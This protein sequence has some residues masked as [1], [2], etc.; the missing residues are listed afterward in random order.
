MGVITFN[1]LD[2]ALDDD[3]RAA[4]EEADIIIGIDVDTQREFTVFGTPP[5]ES[6]CS[7]KKP[8]AMRIVRIPLDGKACGL[9]RLVDL[10]RAVKGHD[11]TD[12]MVR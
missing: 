7:I 9:D 10:V 5:L 3:L 2:Q 1:S 6:T 8:S 4:L 11:E 12:D